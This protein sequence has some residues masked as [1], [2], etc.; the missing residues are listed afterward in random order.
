MT[1][2][3]APVVTCL[4]IY[5]PSPMSWDFNLEWDLCYLVTSAKHVW[6]FSKIELLYICLLELGKYLKHFTVDR[7]IYFCEFVVLIWFNKL[8]LYWKIRVCTC[9][10]ILSITLR[11]RKYFL[12]PF[13]LM[14]FPVR[15]IYPLFKPFFKSFCF[16]LTQSN[17]VI[18]I[19]AYNKTALNKVFNLKKKT[20]ALKNLNQVVKEEF[21][22]V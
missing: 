4:D 6:N 1:S 10:G 14:S 15:Y 22:V 9:T 17:V 11:F 20:F 8:Y 2:G 21:N 13:D 3:H 7:R 18:R 12:S 19:S 5:Y 16:R